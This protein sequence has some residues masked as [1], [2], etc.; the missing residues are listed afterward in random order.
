MNGMY[1]AIKGRRGGLLEDEGGGMGE[2][3]EESAPPQGAGVD[4][5][6]LVGALS[7]DQKMQLLKI[8]VSSSGASPDQGKKLPI[9]EGGQSPG[10]EDDLEESLGEGHESEDQIAES[11][12]AS[13]DKMRAGSGEKPRNLGERMKFNLASKLKN[14]GK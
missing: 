3:M 8:L 1:S 12:I 5:K 13:S 2:M 14:K 9:E 11:M 10:E 7:Q 4:M 6:S